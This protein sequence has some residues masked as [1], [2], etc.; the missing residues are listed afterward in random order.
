MN[1]IFAGE[2]ITGPLKIAAVEGPKIQA[3]YSVDVLVELVGYIATAANHCE[4]AKLQ[5]VLDKL[6]KRLKKIE[7]SYIL[8]D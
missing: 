7:E 6:F 4:D 8:E 5:R 2:D 1:D 3:M